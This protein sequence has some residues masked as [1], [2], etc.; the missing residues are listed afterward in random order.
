[1]NDVIFND[2]GF[3]GALRAEAN[4]A[5]NKALEEVAS[6]FEALFLQQMMKSMRDAVPK[7]DLMNS[8]HMET[9]QSMADQQMSLSLSREGGIGLARMLV[10]QLQTR[11]LVSEDRSN[12]TEMRAENAIGVDATK[13]KEFMTRP[14]G[15]MTDG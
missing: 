15:G 7:G 5:P 11:G 10:E 8:D 1:M 13:N 14:S 3:L 4:S 9:F 2:I 12:L 6:Q